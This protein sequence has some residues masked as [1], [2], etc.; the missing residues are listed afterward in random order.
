MA[1]L[2]IIAF[3]AANSILVAGRD[4]QRAGSA[5]L[6]AQAEE[7]LVEITVSTARREDLFLEQ[8]RQDARNA[9]RFAAS[10]FEHPQAFAREKY[11]RAED[12][13]FVV[14]DGQY[15]NG[16]EDTSTV[17][18]PN[19]VEI[20]A[21]FLENLEQAAFLNLQFVPM[22][23]SNPGTAAIYFI[24]KQEYSWLYPNIN[25]GAILPPDFRA[26]ED[27]FFASGAP[28]NNPKRE[29]VWTTI[30]DDPAGQGLLVTAVAPIYTNDNEFLGIIGIDIS[31]AELSSR[32]ETASPV[33]G[34]YLLLT[35]DQRRAIAL[36]EQGYMDILGRPPEV[37]EFGADLSASRAAFTPVLEKMAAGH[38][39]FDS[40]DLDGREL[41]VA[42][43]P[44]ER[45]GWS[46]ATVVEADEMLQ[47]ISVL[48]NE[49]ETSTQALILT[50]ILPTGG[51]ILI[52]AA[53]VGLF[54]TNRLVS[55]IQRLATTAQRVG[56]GEWNIPLPHDTGIT[57]IDSLS[58]AF[59][60]MTAQLAELVE[61]L[62][63][64]SRELEE[65]TRELEASQRVTFAASER[66]A[67]DAL[68]DLAVNLVRDQFHLYHVQVYMVDE[69]KQAAVLRKSTGY[70]GRRLVQR[71]HQIPLDRPALVTQ[72]IHEGKPA[73]VADVSQ[74]PDFMP[75]PLLP[76]TRSELVV[77]LKLGSNV[78]GVLDAQD[79]EP[80]RF[81][82]N[83][84][85]LFQTMANQIA[86]LFENS[87]LLH[88]VSGQSET[89]TIFASQLRTAAD[90]ARRL[91]TILDPDRLLQQVVDMMQSRFGLYHAHIYVLESPLSV[92]PPSRGEA[93]K[94]ATGARLVVRAGSDEVGRVLSERRHSIPLA[95]PKSL[96]ARAARTQEMVAV[97][98]TS[99][100]PDFMRNPLLPQTHSELAVPL[101]F[102][103]QVLGVL[104]MQDD[105]A[106][107]FTQTELD[108]FTTLAGQIATALHTAGLFAQVQARFLV[109]Q[110]LTGTQTENNVLDAMVEAASSYPEARISI[111]TLDRDNR[112]GNGQGVTAIMRRD[113]SFDSGIPS[114]F[115]IGIH[116]TAVQFKLF[117]FVSAGESFISPNLPLDERADPFSRD[118]AARQGVVS[119][120]LLPIM[121]GDECLGMITVSSQR[122]GYFDERKLHLYRSLTEQGAMALRTGQLFDETQRTAERLREVDRIKGEFLASMSHELRTPLNSILGYT[123]VMLMG[124]DGDLDPETQEDVQAIYENGQHLLSLIN[125]VLDVAKIEAGYLRLN[126]EKVQIKSLIETAQNNAA[127]LLAKKPGVE[128]VVEAEGAGAFPSIQG[129]PTRL[130]QILNNLISNA[131]KFT[132]EGTVKLRAHRDQPDWICLE[133]EDSGIGISEDDLDKIFDRFHQVDSSESRRAGG[134]GLG[135]PITRHLVEL[136]GGSI[137]VRTQVGEGSTF[138]VRLPV[139]VQEEEMEPEVEVEMEA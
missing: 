85:A 5:V 103:D 40:I 102:G 30:Y 123:E 11:W 33:T 29:V 88:N 1:S 14:A 122:E 83:T 9:A 120:A 135:L 75:N 104:D 105:Q 69:E 112:A 22:Y 15:I 18:V 46:L 80:G 97:N 52:M 54:L 23:E 10:I 117:Q 127:G 71:Q 34:G 129:D 39:G 24:S 79:R 119:V 131:I 92:S 126:M 110:A 37:G 58:Q 81:T 73:I 115:P 84:V 108:T 67:P 118:A 137:Q 50:R 136:H 70:A 28:E 64:R 78:I 111:Y 124:I 94:E 62:E 65:R 55:P 114:E 56:A 66:T 107:R 138:T 128:F 139:Q 45:T 42:Y 27:I 26:T 7:Y 13:M 53:V 91:G 47:A 113:E 95:S 25:L 59:N 130:T 38:T 90:I 60:N 19:S 57:E 2:V 44:L 132:D 8:V 3:L 36:P 93:R 125:D 109:S 116:L 68:L 77:P 101:V 87:D 61:G 41:F 98:D 63:Q 106:G 48:Q 76:H 43:T 89:L 20:D 86:F 21:K 99:L 72:A 82:E 121:A 32:I 31:L 96:V 100:V 4:A 74:E 17:F 49:V 134:T 16:E 6:R 133:V 12:H 35:N 51:L